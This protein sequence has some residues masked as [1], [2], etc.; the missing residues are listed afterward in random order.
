[1]LTAKEDRVLISKFLFSLAEVLSEEV[2]LKW[3]KDSHSSRGWTVF[4]DQVKAFIEWLEKA[5]EGNFH[6]LILH[7]VRDFG[8][9]MVNICARRWKMEYEQV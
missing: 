3:H 7:R 9:G 1:M 2:I 4:M 8:L 6:F 5:E